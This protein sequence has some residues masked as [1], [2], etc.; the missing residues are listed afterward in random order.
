MGAIKVL[1]VIPA[2]GGSKGIPRKNLKIL[3]GK[4]LVVYIIEAALKA[5][6]LNR[7]IVSTEDE[8]IA[9]MARGYGAEVPFL[10]PQDL[11][12]DEVSLIPVVKHAVEY[13]DKQG[14]RADIVVSLQPTSP[15]TETGDIDNAVNKML[16]TNCDS[17]VSVYR[18]ERPHPFWMMRLE[19]ERLLPLFPA[20]FRF[21]QRQ[22]LPP[23]FALSGAIYV[24][25]RDLLEGWD[26][27]DFALGGETRAIIMDK[28]KSVDI[29]SPLDFL[30]VEAILKS[31]AASK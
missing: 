4:P 21:L 24:R 30:T 6:T 18:I 23:L 7:V 16:E 20:G 28:E 5:K 8:E 19:G 11:A 9:A 2:R 14:W 27:Q 22:D 1:A 10:R 13:L 15:L 31:K 12:R 25:K 26:G 17:V 3:A 29:N